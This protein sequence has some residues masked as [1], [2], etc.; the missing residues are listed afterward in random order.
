MIKKKKI[1][2]LGGGQLG[3]FL[4]IA[5]KRIGKEITVYSE[6]SEF[7]AEK[8]ANNYF[9]GKYLDF[10]KMDKFLNE[11]D[12]VTIETENIPL[13]T[14]H[15]IN[16]KKPLFPSLF[17][18][19]K[20]QHR[21]KEKEFLNVV[22]GLRTAN[23]RLINS[24]SDLLEAFNDF[25][26]KTIIKSCEQGYDGKNQYTINSQNI[27]EFRN[28]N[29]N[30]FIAEEIVEFKKEISVIVYR[31]IYGNVM[32][33]P[34]V[35]NNHKDKILSETIFPAKINKKS[36][37]KAICYAKRIICSLNMVGLLA[38]EMFLLKNNDIIINELAPRPHNSGHWTLDC[39]DLNQFDNLILTICGYKVQQPKINTPRCKMI[40]IIGENYNKI[41]NFKDYKFYDYYKKKV[42]PKRKMGHLIKKFE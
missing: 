5:A 1:G 26:K 14:L 10:S 37:E 6:S 9:I 17:A 33:Y 35:E 18:I 29:F 11:V 34:P 22:V 15:Y 12:L 25:E 27:N 31:D 24:Y 8:F 39:C 7:S 16:K 32:N 40:N 36:H 28:F 23:Y 30:D 41:N 20:A 21:D 4:C 3:M 38:V 42:L 19:E 2:V 13:D